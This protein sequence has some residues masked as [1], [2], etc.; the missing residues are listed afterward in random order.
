M[1]SLRFL[2]HPNEVLSL[3]VD[4]LRVKLKVSYKHSWPLI[5][6]KILLGLLLLKIHLEGSM[7]YHAQEADGV[8]VEQ[9]QE[10][11]HH[12]HREQMLQEFHREQMLLEFQQEVL[13]PVLEILILEMLVQ[14]LM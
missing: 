7:E 8:Q 1:N 2:G 5:I 9:M 4:Q 6:C 14:L 11:Y 12:H 13:I 10:Y 3:L